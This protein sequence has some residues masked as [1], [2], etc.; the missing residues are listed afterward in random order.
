MRISAVPA[1]TVIVGLGNPV[2]GDD[3]VGVHVAERL[4]RDPR[5]PP[6]TMVV[7][8]GTDLLRVAQRILGAREVILVDA[9]LGLAAGE[10]AIVAHE[11]LQAVPSR[12]Y[13]HRLS[14]VDSVELLVALGALDAARVKWALV[15]V[16]G[17]HVG[18]GLS[19]PVAAAVPRAIAR[20]LDALTPAPVF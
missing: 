11:A 14:A 8:G 7:E 5:L 17:V 18:A 6:A 16:D 15:G 1:H 12:A 20:I 2:A 19:A 4:A 13:A 10:C 3:G 9:T